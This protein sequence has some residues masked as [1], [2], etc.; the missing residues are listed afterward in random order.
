[1]RQKIIQRALRLSRVNQRQRGLKKGVIEFDGTAGVSC[2]VWNV[3]EDGACIA[4]ITPPGIP[5]HFDL[6]MLSDLS[7]RT[8]RVVWR[9]LKRNRA[10]IQLGVAFQ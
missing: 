9:K 7:R 8:C 3:S 4:A 10:S 1:M 6:V 2:T 5:D